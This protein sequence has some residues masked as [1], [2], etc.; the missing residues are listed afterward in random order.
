MKNLV[1]AYT[2]SHGIVLNKSLHRLIFLTLLM[3]IFISFFGITKINTKK[4]SKKKSFCD[5]FKRQT[6]RCVIDSNTHVAGF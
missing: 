5:L 3:M 4:L 1:H 6:N 2:Y